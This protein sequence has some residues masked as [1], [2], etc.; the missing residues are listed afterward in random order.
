MFSGVQHRKPWTCPDL[1]LLASSLVGSPRAGNARG[2]GI[3]LTTDRLKTRTADAGGG[4]PSGTLR[5][6]ARICHTESCRVMQSHTESYRVIQSHTESLCL[7]CWSMSTLLIYV[8][9]VDLCPSCWSLPVT[10]IWIH[11]I[12]LCLSRFSISNTL[13]SLRIELFIVTG[14]WSPGRQWPS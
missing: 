10:F 6:R 8:Y 1:L 14:G 12:V 2:R 11:C 3:R 13:L 9:P 7:P 5:H 4:L